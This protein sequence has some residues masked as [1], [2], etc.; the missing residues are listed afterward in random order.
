[1]HCLLQGRY[2]MIIHSGHGCPGEYT[3]AYVNGLEA[4]AMETHCEAF[5]RYN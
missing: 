2:L 4:E 1:M 5:P 3:R